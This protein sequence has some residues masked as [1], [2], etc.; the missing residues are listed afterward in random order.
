[1]SDVSGDVARASELP[2]PTPAELENVQVVRELMAAFNGRDLER[3]LA[4]TDPDVAF[5]APQTA[6]A[7][8]RKTM[9]RGHEGIRQY[10]ADVEKVWRHLQLIP[11]EFQA[12]D[13]SV[14]VTGKVTGERGGEG[15][16]SQAAW[17]WKLRVGKATWARAYEGSKEAFED[18]GVPAANTRIL[19]WPT[20]PG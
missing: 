17:G 6:S 5:F 7:V 4:L 12:K 1:M 11:H 9:Y 2:E 13:E 3:F 18:T 8:G 19:R 15:L 20:P 10:F 16:D 14:V